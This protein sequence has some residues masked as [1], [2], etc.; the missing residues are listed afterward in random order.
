MI[1]FKCCHLTDLFAYTESE[2]KWGVIAVQSKGN[3]KNMWKGAA[4]LVKNREAIAQLAK[5]EDAKKLMTMLQRQGKVQDAADAAAEGAPDKLVSMVNQL[6]QS[7][8]GAALVNRIEQQAKK[9][10][11][12]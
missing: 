7:Q 5:S 1:I 6:M 2:I 12:E 11:L 4:D 3:Q 9:A 8:E 10:G